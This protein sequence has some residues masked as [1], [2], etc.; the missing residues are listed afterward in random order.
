MYSARMLRPSLLA[1]ALLLICAAAR[2]QQPE[3]IYAP[4]EITPQEQG[5]NE[6]GVNVEFKFNYLTDYIWR[7]IDRSES[8]GAEDS[9]N[10]QF[11]GALKW[12]LGK[13][14]HLFIGVFTNVYNSDP[15]SRFQEVRPYFGFELTARPV[16]LTI[17]QSSYIFPE[18]DMF[19]TA[20]LWG[21][22]KLDD[23]YFFRTDDPVFGP[24]IL[25]AYDYDINHGT[26]VEF[27][28]SHDFQIE[29]T[30]LT[31]TPRAAVAYVDNRKDFR[32]IGASPFDPAFSSGTSG[33][34]SGFQHY[35]VGLE[36]TYTLNQLL[37]I[38]IRYG[39]LDLKSYLF[40]TDGIDNELR[41][42]TELW[43]GIGLG[44]SY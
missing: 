36:L 10:L 19:N 33:N 8:G 21:R 20:E 34:D 11:D 42:D 17:G 7:G 3:S 30:A 41:A 22:I 31:L 9:P 5:V 35:E 43:G 15:A 28:I 16:I 29:D 37:N 24:Y 12:D 44:F 13:W 38:P 14:P 4:P 32:A 2:A 40:F 27:G 18:R 23:S 6:G 25:A 39:K 1:I 26:Y